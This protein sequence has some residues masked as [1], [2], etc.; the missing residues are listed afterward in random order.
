MPEQ[1]L[2]GS[3]VIASLEQVRRKRVPQRVTRRRAGDP[4]RPRGLFN[5]PLQDG[6]VQVMPPPLAGLRVDVEPG[7]GKYPLPGPFT[8]SV[9]I[10]RS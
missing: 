2:D 9:G 3:D 10:L 1:L 8:L 4:R 6:F 7:G 5:R